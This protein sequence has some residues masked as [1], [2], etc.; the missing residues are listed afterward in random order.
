MSTARTFGSVL[1]ALALTLSAGVARSAPSVS[2]DA[3]ARAITRFQRGQEL[4]ADRDFAGALSEFHK[5]Y[6]LAPSYRLLYDIGQVCYQMHDYVC[7][8]Q[9]RARYLADGGAEIP[10]PRRLAVERELTELQQRLGYL[11]LQVDVAGAE[12]SVDDVLAGVA[13]LAQ[14]ISV[15]AGRHRATVTAPGR[16]PVTRIVD[17]AGQDTAHVTIALVALRVEREPE[18]PATVLAMPVQAPRA[19]AMTTASWLGYG[20]GGVMVA[21]AAITGVLAL[22]AGRD[23][24][25]KLYDD[26]VAAVADRS[27]ASSLALASDAFI[28][29]AALTLT[30]TTVLT[31]VLPRSSS[32]KVGLTVTPGRIDGG[33]S[34]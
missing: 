19:S 1:V 10:A 27:R 23:V 17:V 29:G 14:P 28:I 21:G 15:S 18:A 22:D 30:A 31:F 6:E 9:S 4:Y 24:R 33:F 5:A 13:P 7:A 34:F 26:T 11:D 16:V 8:Q 3:R 12:V 2:D 32:K 20:A 25:S